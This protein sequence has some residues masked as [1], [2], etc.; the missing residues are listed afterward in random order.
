MPYVYGFNNPM[1]FIDPDG[2]NPDDIIIGGDQKIRMIAFYDLQK[3]TSEK[4]VLL[5]TG[6]VTAANKVEKGDEIEFTGDVDMDRNGNAVEKKADTALVAD[7]MKHDEQNN[8][9]V[10]I[11]PTTGEDKTVNTYG[12]NSTVYYNYTISN[13]K[14]APSF[15]IINV[16]GTSGARLFIF[17]GHE[18][19]HSQQFKHQTYDN[20]II[21]GYKDVDSGLLNAMTKSE[22]EARQKE[23]EIRGEQNIKLRKMAPLP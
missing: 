17:L 22:Y 8:T 14:D 19:V 2:M 4:L 1:R 6:V 20:S 11:L 23:N 5:N 21:Q 16:D 12:T 18:L 7:L 3:L 13:G 15:P 10:T 9:D